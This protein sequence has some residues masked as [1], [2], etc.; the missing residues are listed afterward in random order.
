MILDRT[1]NNLLDLKCLLI[2]N[3]VQ[4]KFVW[5]VKIILGRTKNNLLGFKLFL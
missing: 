1:K 4:K 5:L 2:C 3:D